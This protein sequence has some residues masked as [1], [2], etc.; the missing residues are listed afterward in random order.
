MLN[1]KRLIAGIMGVLVLA[2]GV[3][4]AARLYKS[5]ANEVEEIKF[6]VSSAAVDD[7][8]VRVESEA[9]YRDDYFSK[10]STEYNNDLAALSL[11]MA[12]TASSTAESY[13]LYGEEFSDVAYTDY[14]NPDPRT[15]RNAYL[16]NTYKNMGFTDDVYYKYDKSLNDTSDT[17]A[18]GIAKKEINVNNTK[19]NLVNV[20]IRSAS[21]GAEWASN[22]RISN[23]YNETGFQTAADDVF[24]KLKKYLE[25]NRLTGK[26]TKVWICGFSR[27]AGVAN[28]AAAEI[29][30]ACRDK[31]FKFD[32]DNVYSYNIATP[33]G[34][35]DNVQNDI[36]N[37]LYDNIMNIINKTDIVART[38]PTEWGYGRYGKIYYIDQMHVSGSDL[39]RIEKGKSVDLDAETIE[40]IKNISYDYNKMRFAHDDS[41]EYD[42]N[43]LY[44]GFAVKQ[45]FTEAV[46]IAFGII[47][48]STG[49][50]KERWQ[51][52]ITEIVPFAIN[53][54]KKYDPST[55]KW[56]NYETLA[57]FISMN[58]DL[59]IINR[60]VDA[61]VFSQS[62]YNE[63]I[64]WVENLYQKG[65]LDKKTKAILN[66]IV[67]TY[68]GI[69]ILAV[70]YGI[71]VDD[72]KDVTNRAFE[73]LGEL[74]KRCL[75]IGDTL[76][77][78]MDHFCEFYL[79]WLKNYDVS[80]NTIIYK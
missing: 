73:R 71:S 57:E 51:D 50:Y 62:D 63:K 74:V 76:N 70:Y 20:A 23:E 31:V 14:D 15:A 21:Y 78:K 52:V 33:Q 11:Q 19:Y 13:G 16:V 56:V 18:F 45:E 43:K 28:I 27:G 29:D 47:A 34:A 7:P 32:R 48:N 3:L 46:D 44:H 36:H 17:V 49:E 79:A 37:E 1:N 42:M 25:D 54:T 64:E 41:E 40:L 69:R 9:K 58:Y 80:T 55:G 8:K 75:P 39:D 38:A 35:M 67:D 4:G 12:I 30:R 2:T 68:Y 59:D 77:F 61:G 60:A 66:K 53:Q 72:V 10:P 26:K 22:Y 6:T 5:N 24:E 65:M